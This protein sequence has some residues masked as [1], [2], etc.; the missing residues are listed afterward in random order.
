VTGEIAPPLTANVDPMMKKAHLIHDYVVAAN[1]TDNASATPRMSSLASCVKCLEAGLEPV[2]QLAARDR[3]RYAIESEVLG[4]SAL[5]V[6]NIL[7]LT[8]DHLRLGPGPTPKPDQNDMDAVQVLWMLRRMRDD[9]IYID[10]REIKTTPKYFLGAAAS[11]YAALPRYEALRLEKKVNAGAQFI[12]TQPVFDYGRFT[13][14]LEAVEKR[15][16]LDKVYILPGI[17][18]LKSAKAAHLMADVPGVVLPPELIKRMDNAKDEKEE[19]VA[20][21]LEIIEKLRNT[22]GIH[23]LHIMAVHWEEI[24]PRLIDES[25]LP[26]PVRESAIPV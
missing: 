24:M 8:G 25:G 7:C 3:T 9:G 5:G 13:E 4:A 22:K 18:P 2:L 12:Q 6:R 21:A 16:I 19:G 11:P 10:G 23:G 20:I 26:K 15:N 14:W 1:F 17:I